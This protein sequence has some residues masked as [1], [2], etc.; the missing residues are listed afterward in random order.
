MNVP[1]EKSR[2]PARLIRLFIEKICQTEIA[3]IVNRPG[4]RYMGYAGF[5]DGELAD[6]A[7]K[8]SVRTVRLKPCSITLRPSSAA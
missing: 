8:Q 2:N 1:Q 4:T 7:L 6:H 5:I 3:P